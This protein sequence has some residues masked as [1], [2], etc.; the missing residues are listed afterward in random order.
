MIHP[1]YGWP[2]LEQSK[3]HT[4]RRKC[5][6]E[7]AYSQICMFQEPARV[8]RPIDE[9]CR[10]KTKTCIAQERPMSASDR[11]SDKVRHSRSSLINLNRWSERRGRADT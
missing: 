1:L 9:E 11:S 10:L 4:G 5:R 8:P 2:D 3:E 6:R 7:S